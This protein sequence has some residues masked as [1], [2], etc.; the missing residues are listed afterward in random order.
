M[1]DDDE[2]T[3]ESPEQLD[4]DLDGGETIR[5]WCGVGTGIRS[6]PAPALVTTPTLGGVQGMAA[7]QHTGPRPLQERMDGMTDRMPGHGPNGDCW[8]WTG[9]LNNKGYGRINRNK[10]IVY[11][12][13]L[14]YELAFG[15]IPSGM[16]VLHRCDTPACVNPSHLFLGTQADN[17]RD[18]REKGRHSCGVR[19]R[20]EGHGGAKLTEAKVLEIR[21]AYEAGEMSQRQLATAFGVLRRSIMFILQRRHWTHV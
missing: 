7:N 4:A 13:R 17:N 5:C 16:E 20:G 11:A 2:P 6:S 3:E 15:S 10:I 21:R 12:H 14:A 19:P 18:C 1:S 8:V 9:H